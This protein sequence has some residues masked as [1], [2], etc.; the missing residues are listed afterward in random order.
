MRIM[1]AM[2]RDDR[3]NALD[4]EVALQLH[5][6]TAGMLQYKTYRENTENPE[7]AK[8]HLDTACKLLGDEQFELF[9]PSLRAYALDQKAKIIPTSIT[10]AIV[11]KGLPPIARTI[12]PVGPKL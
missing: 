11:G 12:K 9:P 4:V 2:G 5:R 8:A 3:P 6:L 1:N 7:L 10:Y